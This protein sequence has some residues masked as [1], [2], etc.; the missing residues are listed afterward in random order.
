MKKILLLAALISLSPSAWAGPLDIDYLKP[1]P[2]K[3]LAYSIVLPGG[4]YFYLAGASAN[5]YG[6]YKIRGALYFAAGVAAAAWAITE[7]DKGS[8]VAYLGVGAFLGL[9][10]LEF[11]DVTSDAETDR[12]TALK[13]ALRAEQAQD[14][15]AGRLPG[16]QQ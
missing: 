7:A 13:D 12:H 15:Q 2:S 10:I 11:G 4:G 9:R 14:K 1:S 8:S 5:P 6:E 16:V 3:A